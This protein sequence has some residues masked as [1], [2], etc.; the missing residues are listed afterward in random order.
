MKLALL[1]RIGRTARR[2]RRSGLDA[3]VR[4]RGFHACRGAGR[5][6]ICGGLSRTGRG[7]G[8]CI[9]GRRRACGRRGC[10]RRIL[11]RGRF[12]ARVGTSGRTRRGWRTSPGAGITC[13]GRSLTCGAGIGERLS[14]NAA[15]SRGAAGLSLLNG[16][17][18]LAEAHRTV[19]RGRKVGPAGESAFD[20]SHHGLLRLFR[21]GSVGAGTSQRRLSRLRDRSVHG[22]QPGLGGCHRDTE[23]IIGQEAVVGG[24][25]LTRFV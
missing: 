2:L 17:R 6:G 18:M 14:D 4:V 9:C 5:R 13:R 12:A 16:S 15:A 25:S 21:Y 8:G 10:R 11:C 23:R 24:N 19:A 22:H 3:L 7:G 1:G 20:A